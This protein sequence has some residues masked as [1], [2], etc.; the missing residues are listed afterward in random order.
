MGN[1]K[2]VINWKLEIENSYFI[3]A[4]TSFFILYSDFSSRRNDR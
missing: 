1:W 2:L 4:P 3:F